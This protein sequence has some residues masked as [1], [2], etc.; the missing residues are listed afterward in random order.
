MNAIQYI[1]FRDELEKI[2]TNEGA[3][4][5]D[6]SQAPLDKL[7]GLPSPLLAKLKSLGLLKIVRSGSVDRSNLLSKGFTESQVSRI[8]AHA[9]GRRAAQYVGEEK[10]LGRQISMRA[11]H[12][13]KDRGGTLTTLRNWQAE[14]AALKEKLIAEGKAARKSARLGSSRLAEPKPKLKKPGRAIKEWQAGNPNYFDDYL[15][16]AGK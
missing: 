13:K 7:A 16:R 2:A 1:A 4:P 6:N 14:S 11:K 12:M 5:S 15:R 3:R 8:I 10:M 9:R